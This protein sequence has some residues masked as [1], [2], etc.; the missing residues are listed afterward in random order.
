MKFNIIIPVR[1]PEEGKS[2]LAAVLDPVARAA[3]VER[4]C[5]HVLSVAVAGVAPTQVHVVSRS[6]ALLGLAK[7]SG[8]LAILEE[9]SGL[10]PALEQAAALC[11]P[12][13]PVLALSADLPLLAPTDIA[14]MLKALEQADVILATDCAGSG[15]NALLLRRPNLVPYT[16]GTGSLVRHHAATK[17]AGLRFAAISRPGLAADLDLPEDL[18]LVSAA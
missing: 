10:N 4:M 7:A 6:P 2:R 8:A 15:T 12:V 3:L 14:D 16:F 5:R 9:R 17:A 1:P 11:D 18:A 13:L